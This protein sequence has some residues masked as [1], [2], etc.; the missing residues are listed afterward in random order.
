LLFNVDG[1]LRGDTKTRAEYYQ[2]M[3]L[4]KILTSNE[5]RRIEGFNDSDEESAKTLEGTN[6]IPDKIEPVKEQ[7]NTQ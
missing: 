5:I 1:L 6:N 7:I 2:M 4:N 3:K